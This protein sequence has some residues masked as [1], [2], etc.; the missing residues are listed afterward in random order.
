M[1]MSPSDDHDASAGHATTVRGHWFPA[2]H[3]GMTPAQASAPVVPAWSAG[4]QAPWMALPPPQ[5]LPLRKT[6]NHLGSNLPK[7]NSNYAGPQQGIRG[8]QE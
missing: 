6:A 8:T 2:I 1:I 5:K 3:A 7:A 4:T